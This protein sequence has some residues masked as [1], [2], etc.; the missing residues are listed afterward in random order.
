MSLKV[1]SQTPL[2]LT[3][4]AGE[5]KTAHQPVLGPGCSHSSPRTTTST[6]KPPS[7]LSQP[8]AYCHLMLAVL[9]RATGIVLITIVFLSSEDERGQVTTWH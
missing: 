2:V 5:L 4:G 3:V 8:R 9:V 6:S 7:P 1:C